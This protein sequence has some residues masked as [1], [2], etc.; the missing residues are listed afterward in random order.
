MDSTIARFLRQRPLRG[1][2]TE[3][4]IFSATPSPQLIR[5]IVW[6]VMEYSRVCGLLSESEVTVTARSWTSR[7][8]IRILTEDSN[9]KKKGRETNDGSGRLKVSKY[10][11][12]HRPAFPP[13]STCLI[14]LQLPAP[15]QQHQRTFLLIYSFLAPTVSAGLLFTA[16]SLTALQRRLNANPEV[17]WTLGPSL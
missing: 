16:I 14:G 1:I 10:L 12:P 15:S 11:E 2:L 7:Q 13:A 4:I 6:L 5:A 9:V 17:R 3:Y 8:L